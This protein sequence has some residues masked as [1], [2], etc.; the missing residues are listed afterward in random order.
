MYDV[1]EITFDR[2]F[3]SHANIF[4]IKFEKFENENNRTE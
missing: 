1:E 4:Y 3:V 2:E